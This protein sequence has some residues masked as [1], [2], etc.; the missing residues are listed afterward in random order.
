MKNLILVLSIFLVFFFTGCSQVD[1]I[2]KD[3][4]IDPTLQTSEMNFSTSKVSANSNFAKGADVSWL[5]EM[6]SKG[7]KFRKADSFIE[8]DLFLTLKIKGIN[9]IRLRVF[10]NPA[11]KW[12]NQADV[13]AKAKRAK[14]AGMRIMIDFHYSDEFADPDDQKTPVAWKNYSLNEATT[15]VYNHTKNVLIALRNNGIIPEWVQVGNE[16]DDGMMWPL[17]RVSNK[18]N[19]IPDFKNFAWLQRS[20]YN[21][22]KEIFPFA[23]VIVHIGVSTDTNLVVWVMEGLW[24]NGAKWDVIGLSHYPTPENWFS[25]NAKCLANMSA[26]VDKYNSEIMICE[27]G[28]SADKPAI[29]Q[30][31]LANLIDINRNLKNNRGIGVFYWEPQCY[32]DWSRYYKGAFND[33]GQPTIALDAFKK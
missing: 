21:A 6:E 30:A 20:G 14:A 17:G 12:C 9:S 23:K 2:K 8:Q 15:A 33:S 26:L 3:D 22:V 5:T 18:G 32:K 13:I 1:E 11:N 19:Q 31:F 16:T 7:W 27:T 25:M 10:V 24:K 29:T 28:M 4:L